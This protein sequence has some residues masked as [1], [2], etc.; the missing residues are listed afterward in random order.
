MPIFIAAFF[1]SVAFGS[2]L[3]Q[4]YLSISDNQPSA[5]SIYNVGFSLA[6]NETIGSFEIQFCSNSP[7]VSMSCT[8]PSG[9]DV[10]GATLTG[11]SGLSGYTIAGGSNTY[12]W[13]LSNPVAPVVNAGPIV[14][15]FSGVVN[16]SSAGS[17]YVRLETFASTNATGSPLDVGGIAFSINSAFTVS[18]YVPPYLYF[19]SAVQIPNYDCNQSSGSYIDFGNLSTHSTAAASSQ[20][21]IATNAQNGYIIQL[22]GSS[23]TSGNNVLP[24]LTSPSPSIVNQDQFGMNLVSN[25][26]PIVG[27]NYQ[28]VGSGAPASGY[29]QPNIFKFVPGDTVASSNQPSDY[30]QFT[31]SYIIN[32]NGNQ[33]PGIYATTLTYVAIANF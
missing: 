7:I 20:L 19:C 10:S 3:T 25:T 32:I 23:L 27:N 13:I 18:T 22:S 16:P 14:F 8:I 30:R 29:N 5:T 12:T 33:P 9:M 21:V 31:V 17:Y 2:L 6:S 26:Q 28:G 4:N 15:N 24:A 11:Q 1:S